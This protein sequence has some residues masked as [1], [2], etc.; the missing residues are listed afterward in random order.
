M[1]WEILISLNWTLLVNWFSNNIDNSSKGLWPNWHHDW[2]ASVMNLLSSNDTLSG[3]ESDSSHIFATQMLS[4]FQNQFVLDPLHFECIENRWQ[5]A[6]EL[7][8]DNSANDL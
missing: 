7:Y 1:D 6:F 8:I 5:V 4:D 2:V 3:V